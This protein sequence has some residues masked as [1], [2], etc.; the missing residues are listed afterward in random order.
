MLDY[1]FVSRDIIF[2]KFPSVIRQPCGTSDHYLVECEVGNIGALKN[3]LKTMLVSTKINLQ[4]NEE[5]IGKR[6]MELA[7]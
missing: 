2:R 3:R 4:E 1:V 7:I 6:F 5:E